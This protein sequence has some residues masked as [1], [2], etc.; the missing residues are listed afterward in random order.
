MGALVSTSKGGLIPE[1]LQKKRPLSTIQ[2]PP[3]EI[4]LRGMI[5]DF[6]WSEKR[7]KIKSLLS[8]FSSYGLD[9]ISKINLI[10]LLFTVKHTVAIWKWSNHFIQKWQKIKCNLE[11]ENDYHNIAVSHCYQVNE[12]S[13]KILVIIGGAYF[14]KHFY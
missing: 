9:G 5:A 14:L 6:S 8:F 10:L 3:K 11:V 2:C 4:L 1:N 13:S 12:C 7:S